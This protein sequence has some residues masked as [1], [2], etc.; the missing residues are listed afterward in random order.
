MPTGRRLILNDGTV[1]ENGRAGYDAGFLW[2][3]LPGYTM[4]EAAAIAFDYQKTERIEFK[5]GE[6]SDVYDRFIICRGILSG[7]NEIKVCMVR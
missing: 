6:M 4:Q 3:Y 7:E 1:I 2:M 5:Y